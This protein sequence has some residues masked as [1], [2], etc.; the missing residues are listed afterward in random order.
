MAFPPPTAETIFMEHFLHHMQGKGRWSVWSDGR[1]YEAK[2]NDES[3]TATSNIDALIWIGTQAGIMESTNL[4][5]A[6][7]FIKRQ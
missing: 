1:I 4:A 7:A 2:Y 6:A 3:F 5:D